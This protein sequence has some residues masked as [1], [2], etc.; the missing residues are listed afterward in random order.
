MARIVAEIMPPMTPVPTACWLLEPAPVLVA[1]GS[2][3]KT[4][5]SDVIRIGRKR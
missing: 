4:N 2:T 5:A 3:P 1:I